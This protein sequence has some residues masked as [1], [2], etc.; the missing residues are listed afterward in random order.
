MSQD[1][2]SV[3]S[4]WVQSLDMRSLICLSLYVPRCKVYE[5][6]V[7]MF[8]QDFMSVIY[9]RVHVLGCEVS[10]LFLCIFPSMQ[11]L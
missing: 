2:L 6:F 10:D 8:L 11:G 9:L 1:L 5:L 7:G 3:F 4:L